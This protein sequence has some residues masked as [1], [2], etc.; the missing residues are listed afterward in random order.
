[1]ALCTLL[2]P[3]F[4]KS[5]IIN[6]LHDINAGYE[7]Q[8][9]FEADE[10]SYSTCDIDPESIPDYLNEDYIYL[11]KGN[12]NFT[13]WDCENISG[14]KYSELDSLGRCGSA[15]VMLD[16]SMM[17]T[18]ARGEIGEVKPTG[19]VQH[20][21]RGLVD[22]SPPYLFNRCHLIAY[23][24][25]GQ[26]ANDK[27]LIT[28]TRYMNATTMLLWEEKVMKYLDGSDGH[29]LYRVSP[30]FRD[31]ELL[32]RGVELEAYSVEDEGKSLCFHVFV[33]NIQPGIELDYQTGANRI[34]Q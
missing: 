3:V 5:N 33:Y 9:T 20:K 23:A 31:D 1:M 14:E 17:P 10:P 7:S 8:V 26:N 32:A 16:H 22:S 15:L 13:K 11:N 25:T 2:I 12:P 4:K 18:E 30:L 19:W 27:N 24:L 6:L 28:G 34:A 29:V 21:Y